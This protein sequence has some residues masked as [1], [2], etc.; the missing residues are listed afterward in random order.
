M[1]KTTQQL[2][3]F[4]LEWHACSYLN[5]TLTDRTRNKRNKKRA[6][7]EG[8]NEREERESERERERKRERKKGRERKKEIVLEPHGGQ[9]GLLISLA[10]LSIELVHLYNSTVRLAQVQCR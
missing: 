10:I 3:A 5:T 7:R 2:F 4:R 9:F 8:E 1:R 6:E